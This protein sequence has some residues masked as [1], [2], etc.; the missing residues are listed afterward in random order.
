MK[1]TNFITRSTMKKQSFKLYFMD[2]AHFCTTDLCTLTVCSNWCYSSLRCCPEVLG[3]WTNCCLVKKLFQNVTP[4]KTTTDHFTFL[5]VYGLTKWDTMWK[6]SSFRGTRGRRTSHASSVAL[7][8]ALL[9]GWSVGQPT[10]CVQIKNISIYLLSGLPLKF[11]ETS[12]SPEDG[13]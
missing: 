2:S 7:G 10:T 6:Y 8:M 1:F 5:F 12:T 9:V 11:I 4:L 3:G 13:S